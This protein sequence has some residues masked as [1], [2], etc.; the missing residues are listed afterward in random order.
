MV[1]IPKCRRK[2]LYGGGV[3][4]VGSLFHELARERESRVLEGHLCPDH[5]HMRIE[6]PP[7]HSMAQYQGEK[8]DSNSPE[9]CGEAKKASPDGS[10]GQE[11]IMYQGLVG[12]K[13]PSESISRNKKQKPND[14]TSWKCSRIY[15]STNSKPIAH[16]A[17]LPQS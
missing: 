5:V 6:I 12:R 17:C 4:Y 14:L 15:F 2:Q 10:S 8:C 9:I 13:R 3:K 11:G 7:K 16:N 1:W